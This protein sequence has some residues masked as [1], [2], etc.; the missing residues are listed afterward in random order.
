MKLRTKIVLGFIALILITV[1]YIASFTLKTVVVAPCGY[2]NEAYVEKMIKENCPFNNVLMLQLW[3]RFDKLPKDDCVRGYKIQRDGKHSVIV[4]VDEEIIAAGTLVDGEYVYF[5][6]EGTV[7]TNVT[8]KITG[9]TIVE[10]LEFSN[11]KTGDKLTLDDPGKIN[12]ISNIKQYS[13]KYGIKVDRIVFD[14]GGNIVIY[15]DNL[16]I[17]LGQGEYLAAQFMNLPAIIAKLNG[18]GGVLYMK[19]FTND[20]NTVTFMINEDE[21]A[22][23]LLK[24]EE[25]NTENEANDI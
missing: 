9:V 7:L 4:T 15:I 21:I 10:G 13:E 3:N 6:T 14:K 2:M 5:D 22:P 17:E 25:N 12:K 1:L 8:G 19:D 16:T 18:H 20:N 24:P 11:W 23:E